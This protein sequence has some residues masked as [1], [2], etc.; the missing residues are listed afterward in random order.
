MLGVE[1]IAPGV[2]SI[3]NSLSQQI[4]A[5]TA[6][7]T[8]GNARLAALE[9]ENA[10]LRARVEFL[11][12]ELAKRDATI[13]TLTVDM[14]SLT[15]ACD[16]AVRKAG[17]NSTN[18]SKPPSSDG[19]FDGPQ[20]GPA[21]KSPTQRNREKRAR[22]KQ[23]GQV[24]HKGHHRELLPPERI[25]EVKVF[26]PQTCE[27]CGGH[28]MQA[29][30]AGGFWS[31]QIADLLYGRL[32]VVE[33]QLFGGLCACGHRSRASLPA[34]IHPHFLGPTMTALVTLL[35]GKYRLGKR[36]TR[37]LMIDLFDLEISA[38]TISQCERRMSEELAQPVAEAEVFIQQQGLAAVDETTHREKGKLLWL[39]VAVTQHVV[40]YKI[41]ASR[42][43]ASAKLLLG[44]AFAGIV[45]SD[46]HGAYNW[47]DELRRQYCWAHLYRRFIGFSE[48]KGETRRYGRRLVRYTEL[49]FAWWQALRENRITRTEF[50]QKMTSLVLKVNQTL[51][52]A[53]ETNLPRL[54]G[55]AYGLFMNQGSL[56]VFVHNKDV[57][58]TNNE[59]ERELRDAAIRR[60]LCFG[61]QSDRG[62]RYLE[63]MLCVSASCKRQNRNVFR[64][65]TDAYQAHLAG[66]II[67]SIVPN[68]N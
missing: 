43:T 53:A 50:E 31:H 7:V 24:G 28:E 34:S 67:P 58:P 22:K 65:L 47:V 59:A 35:T 46:Q 16:E 12:A 8:V 40:V 25:H 11:E 37:E 52:E 49:M 41:L 63:R 45:T 23:G 13:G 4:E 20:A 18:S 2:Q 21:K 17:M 51:L 64:Y 61:T 68:L 26:F 32:W 54:S 15:K 56:W 44:E 39:W 55:C 10:R 48:E 27:S 30:T 29:D 66:H 38:S 33:H 14:S 3:I 36:R 5:L 1:P 19:P 62:S 60:K 9:S 42:A 57:Q 6:A